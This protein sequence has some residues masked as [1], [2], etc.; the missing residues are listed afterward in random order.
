KH[1]SLSLSPSIMDNQTIHNTQIQPQSL[2]PCSSGRRRRTSND[3][4]SPEFE[5][6]MVSNPSLPPSTPL[7]ADELFVN[8]FLLPLQLLAKPDREPP[9]TGA[10]PSNP[11][12]GPVLTPTSTELTASKRWIDIFK[13]GD[14][15]VAV[16]KQ[17]EKEKKREKKSQTGVSPTAELNINIWP[18]SRSRS[19]GN[20]GTRP[21][22]VSGSGTRKVSSAP[23]SRSNSAGE[24]KAKKWPHSPGRAGVH[25]GRSSPLWQVRRG[26]KVVSKKE[27]TDP[28]R[29]K[30][31]ATTSTVLNLNVPMCIGYRHHLSC[32]SD[33]NSAF[34][35]GVSGGS[36]NSDA[37]SCVS[38]DG[39][40][41]GGHANNV[42]NS[43]NLFNLRSLFTKKVY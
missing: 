6:W 3:S 37:N 16:K 15:K 28:R 9:N 29:G 13:K 30:T 25:L 27:V 10:Q 14:K 22:I 19:A 11:D 31:V 42:R 40:G 36:C 32:S 23:C 34:G 8:G 33:E 24:S 1:L 18:F 26:E 12:P 5:F 2:S 39:G 35:V 41:S 7:F 43:G 17:E 21:K 38:G 4:N 20:G